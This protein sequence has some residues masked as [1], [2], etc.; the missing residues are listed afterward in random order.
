ML[1]FLICRWNVMRALAALVLFGLLTGGC[2][3]KGPLYLP[4]PKP[5]AAP[6]VAPAAPATDSAKPAPPEAPGR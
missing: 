1:R 5:I 4:P 2:G 6:P 3:Y